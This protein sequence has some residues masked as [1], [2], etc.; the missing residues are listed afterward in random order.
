MEVIAVIQARWNA[1]RF[2]GKVLAYL[3]GKTI[4]RH[5]IDR[6]RRARSVER[7]VVAVGDGKCHEAVVGHL[8][9]WGVEWFLGPE[10]DVLA[11]FCG[12]LALHEN[13]DLCVRVCADNPLIWP[14]GIDLLVEA[15]G[16][17]PLACYCGFRFADGSAAITKGTG[18]FAEVVP[19]RWLR[20]LNDTTNRYLVKDHVTNWFYT[21]EGLPI[22]MLD[23]PDW[24]ITNRPPDTAIDTPEDLRRVE[25]FL[26]EMDSWGEKGWPFK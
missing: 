8:E 12:A 18:W 25:E 3:G 21:A 16:R 19:V 17:N 22:V 6:V 26:E 4:L 11:R 14:R 9:E 2:P 20:W 10:E 24:Y 15:H 5:V 13:D 23:V 1:S 7:L